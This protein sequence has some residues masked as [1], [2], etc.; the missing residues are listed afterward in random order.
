MRAS[1]SNDQCH[2]HVTGQQ[3]V[4]KSGSSPAIT[5][6][7]LIRSESVAAEDQH[8]STGPGVKPRIK[9]TQKLSELCQSRGFNPLI[10]IVPLLGGMFEG[11]V[12]LGCNKMTT[13]ERYTSGDEA[14]EVAARM[15]YDWMLSH[16][17]FRGTNGDVPTTESRAPVVKVEQRAESVK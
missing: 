10:R 9:F 8:L 7:A 15:G 2:E 16:P 6:D 1:Y 13:W 11:K 12:E 14:R 17:D 5:L 4:Q 3:P